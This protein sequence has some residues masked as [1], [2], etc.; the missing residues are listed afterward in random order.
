MKFEGIDGSVTAKGYEKWVELQ[1][2][3]LGT[4]R[5]ITNATGRGTNRE[6]GVPRVSETTITKYQDE[7]SIRLFKAAMYGE[8]KKVKIDFVKTDKDKFEPYMQVE[9]EHTLVSSFAVNGDGDDSHNRVLETL[10]LNF[11]KLI[12]H[13]TQMDS[14]NKTGRPDRAMWDAAQGRG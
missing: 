1:F 11:T 12:Y 14:A 6:V 2:C 10:S 7:A 8:G 9:L 5:T 13:S 4:T 3:S